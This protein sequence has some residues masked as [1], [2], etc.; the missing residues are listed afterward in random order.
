MRTDL[1]FQPNT[2]Y[3]TPPLSPTFPAVNAPDVL[4]SVAI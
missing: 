2:P 4:P 1:D 3:A